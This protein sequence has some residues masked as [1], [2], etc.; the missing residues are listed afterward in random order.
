MKRKG[1][2]HLRKVARHVIGKR[3]VRHHLLEQ[4]LLTTEDFRKS[5]N[6]VLKLF[7]CDFLFVHGGSLMKFM[8]RVRAPHA[9]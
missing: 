1:H 2:S 6:T 5:I 3:S 7:H 4:I 8:D 9:L